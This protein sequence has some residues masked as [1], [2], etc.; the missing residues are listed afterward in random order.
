MKCEASLKAVK[1]NVKQEERKKN[2]IT[3]GMNTDKKALDEKTKEAD[4]LQ[5]MFDKL[6]GE[7]EQ[8]TEALKAAQTRFEAISVG[9]FSSEDGTAATLQEQ[10]IKLKGDISSAGTTIKTGDMKTKH[11]K[12]EMVRLENEM[13]RTQADFAR[14]SGNLRKFEDGVAMAEAELKKL[15]YEPGMLEE[16]EAAHRESKH[17]VKALE[18]KVDDMSARYSW[19]NFQYTDP[20][21]N[22]DRRQVRGPA[23]TLFKVV[24]SK[25]FVALDTAGGGKVRPARTH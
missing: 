16:L 10:I 13:K 14:D 22:F 4:G 7:D 12:K 2:Q 3:K 17:E 24:D 19:L 15:N 5:G 20:E 21:R 11:N 9:K 25:F 18:R 8:C 23:A 1:D 6:R